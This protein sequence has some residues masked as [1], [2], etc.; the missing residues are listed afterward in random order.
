[1]RACGSSV[2]SC[3]TARP[4]LV[5]LARP[6]GTRFFALWHSSKMMTPSKSVPHHCSSCLSRLLKC[7][8]DEE[9]PISAEY[10]QKTT[11]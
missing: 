6:A 10:V 3:S 7:P 11:P 9:T 2:C 4:V 5:A 8:P 1:M